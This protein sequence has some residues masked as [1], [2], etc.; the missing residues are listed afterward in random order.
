[1]DPPRRSRFLADSCPT[2]GPIVEQAAHELGGL[3]VLLGHGICVVASH[4]HGRPAEPGLLLAF[5]D[6]R[7]EDGGLEVTKRVQVDVTCHLGPVSHACKGMTHHIWI[8]GS[9]TPGSKEKT[10]LASSS[11]SRT[12]LRARVVHPGER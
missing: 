4:V 12:W 1:M 5:G 10:K 7:V 9:C 11:R 3:L 2:C 8:R 6:N